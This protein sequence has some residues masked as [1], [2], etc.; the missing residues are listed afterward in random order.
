MESG[1]LIDMADAKPKYKAVDTNGL[2]SEQGSS[3]D[4]EMIDI[5][6]ENRYQEYS[7]L[8]DR[9]QGMYFSFAANIMLY[10]VSV[11]YHVC[12]VEVQWLKKDVVFLIYG[13]NDF[14]LLTSL[15]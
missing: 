11:V 8:A 12:L 7:D 10:V 2:L 3:T 5:S 4:E 15:Y 1:N 6:T 14:Q 9:S 13:A